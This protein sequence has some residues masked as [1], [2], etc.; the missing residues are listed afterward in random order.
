MYSFEVTQLRNSH[1][2]S[3]SFAVLGIASD[4]AHSQ[5][6]QSVSITGAGA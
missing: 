5:P 6:D 4:Q 2:A 3:G 1:A